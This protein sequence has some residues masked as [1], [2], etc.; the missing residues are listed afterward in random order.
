MAR[1]AKPTA[2]KVAEG[3]RGKR[4]LSTKREP[5]FESLVDLQPPDWLTS[6]ARAVWDET[7][8]SFAKIRLLTRGNRLQF[9][10][11]CQELGHYIAIQR[12]MSELAKANDGRMPYTT[13]T[14][15]GGSCINQL[16]AAAAMYHKRALAV[17]RDFGGT[18][19]GL[20]QLAI[21][22]QTSIFDLPEM[23]S[24]ETDHGKQA[25]PA[26]SYYN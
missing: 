5:E 6:E 10:T 24:Q 7:A 26:S 23:S 17:W 9:A 14:K 2:L 25:R 8:A 11:G 19:V 21:D 3:N 13:E 15:N 12:Q 22:V 16:A 1:P 18:P 20:R 4:P